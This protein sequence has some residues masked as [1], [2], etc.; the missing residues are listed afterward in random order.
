MS[1]WKIIIF[2][3]LIS[4]TTVNAQSLNFGGLLGSLFSGNGTGNIQN[5]VINAGLIY[6][7]AD[8][9]VGVILSALNINSA[10]DVKNFLNG[11]RNGQNFK[12]ILAYLAFQYGQENPEF[13]QWFDT[14]GVENPED[15]LRFINGDGGDIQTTIFQMA[16][17]YAENN[18]QYQEWLDRLEIY[19]IDDI[20][21][22]LNGDLDSSNLQDLLISIGTSYLGQN[23]QYSQ[24]LGYLNIVLGLIGGNNNDDV[25]SI[26]PIKEDMPNNLFLGAFDGMS[27]S[28]IKA[29]KASTQT[30]KATKKKR[31]GLFGLFGS[32]Q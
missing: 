7:K 2:C 4:G 12:D 28:Q 24:Y 25:V 8:P 10:D 23:S 20:S 21:M 29:I 30:Q 19:G 15:L 27:V 18:P 5:L 9:R 6:A 3:C 13:T 14:V 16:L 32:R 17:A 31:K 22:I 11:D 26:L 1:K